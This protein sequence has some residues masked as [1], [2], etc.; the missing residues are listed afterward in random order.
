[1]KD[2]QKSNEDKGN[3]D[4]FMHAIVLIYITDLE[5]GTACDVTRYGDDLLRVQGKL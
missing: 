1:M 5:Q 3:E 2:T 4:Q